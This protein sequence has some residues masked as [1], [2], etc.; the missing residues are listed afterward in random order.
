MTKRIKPVRYISKFEGLGKEAVYYLVT[1]S[2]S[3]KEY[4]VSLSFKC[5][6]TYH[7]LFPE[8]QKMCKVIKSAL[9][10]HLKDN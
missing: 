5:T 1:S 6:C 3:K 10:K 9:R 7:S 2:K 8:D 4:P